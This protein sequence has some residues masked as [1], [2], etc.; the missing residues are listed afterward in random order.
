MSEYGQGAPVRVDDGRKRL[1]NE[2]GIWRARA[3]AALSQEKVPIWPYKAAAREGIRAR[4]MTA[5]V[6]A[7]VTDSTNSPRLLPAMNIIRVSRS[8][9]S[10]AEDALVGVRN[11]PGGKP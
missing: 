8:S 9:T 1:G 2:S 10:L 5:H 3:S 6:R 7:R 4:R 11:R